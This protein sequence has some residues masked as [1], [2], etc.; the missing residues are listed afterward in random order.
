MRFWLEDKNV[1][2]F[3]IDAL[4]HLFEDKNFDNEPLVSSARGSIIEYSD[5]KHTKTADQPETYELLSQWRSMFDEISKKTNRT[6]ALIV[7]CTS[8]L[9]SIGNYYFFNKRPSANFA[10]NFEFCS[11]D[12]DGVGFKPKNVKKLIDDYHRHL[13]KK[14][15]SNWQLGNHDQKRVATRIGSENVDLA[16]AL[17]LLVGGTAVVYNGDEIGMEDLPK[18]MLAFDQCMDE[19][20]KKYGV[21][22]FIY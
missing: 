3:R 4:R 7:E 20:G 14:C 18:D 16:N 11:L 10:L 13:P 9:S 22:N 21:L 2:G 12:V 17:N 5:L 15:W 1:D 19:S 6:K 8:E